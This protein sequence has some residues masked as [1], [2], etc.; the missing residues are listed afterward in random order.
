ML[1]ITDSLVQHRL[2]MSV[3][4]PRKFLHLKFDNKGI[5]AVNIN[6]ILN[7]KNVHSCIP[8]Y[9]KMKSTPCI[10]YRYS[11]TIA[12]KL[13]NYKQTLQRLYIEQL[14]LNPQSAHVFLPHLIT[15]PLVIPLRGM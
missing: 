5:D 6:N 4:K 9:F 11:S 1:P 8:P 12:S 2:L 10:S 3:K 7:H 13:F 15:V 14:R